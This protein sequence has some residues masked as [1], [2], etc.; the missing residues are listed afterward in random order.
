MRDKKYRKGVGMVILNQDDLVF[1]AQRIKPVSPYW[2]MPQG[3]IDAN[4]TPAET[5]F[6]E[7]YEETGIKDV[8]IMTELAEWV[9]YDFPFD[10]QN[11][12]WGGKYKGQKQK[13]FLLRFLGKE[14][15][16]NIHSHNQEFT[17][18]QWMHPNDVLKSVV[19]F[20]RDLYHKILKGFN[21]IE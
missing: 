19:P 2:Q 15:D 6:R 12:N 17:Q 11:S 1:V 9:S 18:W 4:E 13:W 10:I 16:I 21:L 8:C 14:E 3:G 5:L 7:L 20:K